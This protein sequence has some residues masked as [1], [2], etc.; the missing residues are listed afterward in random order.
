MRESGR[1][2]ASILKLVSL[3]AVVG[4]TTKELAVIAEKEVIQAGGQA[5]FL[6]YSGGRGIPPFPS[7]ICISVNDEV[8]HGIPGSRCLEEGDIVGLDFGVAY[9]GMIT[10]SAVTVAVGKIPARVKN[11]INATK[12]AMMSGIAQVKNGARVGDL[13]FA[14][15]TRL[16]QDKLGIVEELAGHG[17]GHSLHEEPWIPNFGRRGKGPVLKTGMTIAIEPMATLGRKDVMWHRDGWTI[18]TLDGSLAAHFEHT[19]LVT[20]DGY[21]ILTLWG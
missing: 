8:V 12:E 4:I 3:S 6:N 10:D 9:N 1:I 14:I 20:E 7:V 2:L 15:E 5:P 13:S 19:I 18:S 17:V 16:K 11:L 21:E